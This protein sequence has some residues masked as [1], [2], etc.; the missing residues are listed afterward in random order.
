[1]PSAKHR[2][3]TV[4]EVEALE[5]RGCRA[6]DWAAVQVAPDFDPSRLREVSFHGEV[7]LGRLE[8]EVE[9]LGGVVKPAGIYRAA[10][11][12]CTV[13]DGVRIADIGRHIANYRIEDRAV[14]ENVGVLAVAGEATF[15]NGVTVKT[16]NEAG[17]RGIDI[18]AEMS[19][20][21]AY[22]WA[23]YRYRPAL[24]EALNAMAKR[25]ADEARSRVGRIGAGAVIRG[26]PEIV[27]VIVGPAARITGAAALTNGTILSEP[28]APAVIGTGV[29]ARDFIIGEA[30]SI[31]DGV[32]L[33]HCFVGQGVKM[34]KQYSAEHSLFFAN[35]EGFHGEACSIFAG[36]YTVT[37]HK[38]TLMIAALFSFFNAGSGSN[39]SN[40][41]YKLGPLHQGLLERGCKTGSFSYVLWPCRLA[42]FSVLIGKHSGNFDLSRF[43]FSYVTVEDRGRTYFVPGLNLYTVGTE[44]DRVKWPARDR[45]TEAAVKRDLIRFDIMSP[46]TVGRMLEGEAVLRR[47]VEET[48]RDV[49]EVPVEG[50]LIDRMLLKASV[51]FYRTGVEMYLAGAVVN[52][53]KA[54]LEKGRRLADALADDE[55]AVYSPQWI[56]ASGMLAAADRFE[57][58]LRDVET[59]D[60]D[61]AQG[62]QRALQAVHDAY[63]RDEWAWVRRACR[64]RFGADPAE[65][66]R[67]QLAQLADTYQTARTSFI[68]RVLA[69]AGKEYDKSNLIGFGLD[70]GDDAPDADFHAVRGTYA[71]D[72][73]V[74]RMT[75]DLAD[76]KQTVAD[77]KA[78]LNAPS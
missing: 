58:V 48:P 76:L 54:A 4:E 34:G 69:D 8:G 12:N 1:M 16:V 73:F 25:E 70:G 44:R 55:G 63:E 21:F 11:F 45:R 5:S 3:L 49:E 64:D 61:S 60:V 24:C 47:L 74:Q 33:D 50:G 65:M 32:I 27:N 43:P 42:P 19:S 51:K 13:G 9:G 36:P 2:P 46:F 14:V 67:D 71:D 31:T 78:A 22:L 23:C 28:D 30:S 26:V 62:F 68:N 6:D 37:H 39:Q 56:D 57:A 38:S 7:R 41:M 59:G 53:A 72:E 18:F 77:F 35:A 40:H 52:R 20:Q 10:L 75:A 66:T 29:I 15:G 17:G